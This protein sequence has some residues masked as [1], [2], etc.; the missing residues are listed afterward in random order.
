MFIPSEKLI[1]IHTK[2]QEELEV[3]VFDY[4]QVFNFFQNHED[5]F[6]IYC[7]LIPKTRQLMEFIKTK[8]A[9]N[10]EIREEVDKLT[11]ES[12]NSKWNKDAQDLI[13]ELLYRIPEAMMRYPFILGEIAKEARKEDY[14]TIEKEAQKA[15]EMMRKIMLHVDKCSEDNKNIDTVRKL[16][17]SWNCVG[18]LRNKGLLLMEVRD[19][20]IRMKNNL[21]RKFQCWVLVFEEILVVFEAK[22]KINYQYKKNGKEIELGF[23][24]G[25]P[26][27]ENTS[28]EYHLFRKFKI[29]TFSE[30][31]PIEGGNNLELITYEKGILEDPSRSF[32]ISFSSKEVQQ[33]FTKFIEVQKSKLDKFFNINS[34]SKH[35]NHEFEIYQNNYLEAP[36]TYQ[37]CFECRDFLGG[38]VI[39]A[40]KCNTCEEYFHLP[41]FELNTSDEIGEEEEDTSMHGESGTISVCSVSNVTYL[42]HD[43]TL[44]VV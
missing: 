22:E 38:I 6:L 36:K 10:K 14:I 20:E 24:T 39:T 15:H 44:R 43:V 11:E 31:N 28:M 35:K 17:N 7:E 37:K 26:I 5:E 13:G 41:C 40:I 12:F 3:V 1:E 4:K 42:L 9:S 29:A 33:E 25:E 30:I 23:F 16:E 8:M 21:K 27:I 18:E 2:L 19:V 32:E 34:G